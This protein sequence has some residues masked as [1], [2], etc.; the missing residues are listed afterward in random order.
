[1][2]VSNKP[3]RGYVN[4]TMAEIISIQA[5]VITVL[6]NGNRLKLN[7][8]SLCLSIDKTKS[9][10][11]FP[12]VPAYAITIHK[13]QGLSLDQALIYPDCFASEC[14]IPHCRDL[15]HGWLIPCF[16]NFLKNLLMTCP[17]A[18]EYMQHLNS[19]QQKIINLHGECTKMHSFVNH[20]AHI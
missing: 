11:Q 8:S 17:E 18:T 9:I 2:F 3:K 14:Y 19:L 7:E 15:L 1:M 12:F 16:L 20:S 6:V 5:D 4:G 10:K 13:S